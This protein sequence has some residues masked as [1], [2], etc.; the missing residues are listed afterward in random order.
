ME[1]VPKEIVE[2]QL[3]LFPLVDPDYA[4]GVREAL[5]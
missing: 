1:G 2:R 3:E 5:G 4:R